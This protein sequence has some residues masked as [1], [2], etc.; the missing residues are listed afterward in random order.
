MWKDLDGEQERD[1]TTGIVMRGGAGMGHPWVIVTAGGQMDR[2]TI[3]AQIALS[4]VVR[5]CK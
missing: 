3:V 1:T 2:R 5:T 4:T